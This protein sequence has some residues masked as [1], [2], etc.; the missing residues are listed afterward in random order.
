ME[1]STT[2]CS[3]PAWARTLCGTC[4][5]RK[6]RN[7]TLPD[8]PTCSICS[9]PINFD[10]VSGTCVEHRN[11]SKHYKKYHSDWHLRKTFGISQVDYNQLLKLHGNV[12]GI[13]EK[14]DATGRALAVDHD[15]MSGSVRGLL[16][17][18]CNRG[19]GLLGDSVE[20]LRKAIKYLENPC[21]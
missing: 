17:G 10:A 4:Y 11:M 18:N 5:S 14:P 9:K 8:K 12:C 3:K 15:H 2:D 16:C 13:C 1:C 6:R 19:I 21:K 20:D 7:G